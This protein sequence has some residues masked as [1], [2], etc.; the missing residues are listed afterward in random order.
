MLVCALANSMSAFERPHTTLFC[1]R[2]NTAAAAVHPSRRHTAR[3]TLSVL[4]S[5][6][7]PASSE[8]TSADFTDVS[9]ELFFSPAWRAGRLDEHYRPDTHPRRIF[10]VV[11]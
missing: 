6:F 11:P 4:R 7:A 10:S 5:E 8:V 9:A 1:S 3:N 2:G